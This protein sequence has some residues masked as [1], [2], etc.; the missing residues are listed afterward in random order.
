MLTWPA[1]WPGKAVVT[2]LVVSEGSSNMA[3]AGDN[4]WC[5]E[6]V[7]FALHYFSFVIRYGPLFDRLLTTAESHV[8]SKTVYIV[9]VVAT[10]GLLVFTAG[11]AWG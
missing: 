9:V 7:S 10:W 11:A 8:E 6:P 4:C 2:A 1:A 5:W 3:V